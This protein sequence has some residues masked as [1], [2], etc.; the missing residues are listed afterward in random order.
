MSRNNFITDH[1]RKIVLEDGSEFY[2]YG[3]GANVDRVCELVFNTSMVGYQEIISDPANYCQAVVM[4]YPLIGNYG[5]SDDDFE[6][7]VP[8]VGGLIVRDYNDHPSNFSYTRTLS[9]VMEDNGVPGIYGFD[10]RALTRKI[11]DNGSCKVLFTNADTP[12][13]VAK[14]IINNAE[15]PHDSV[16][17]VSTRKRW[18]SRTHNPQFNIIAI[19][20]GI[21]HNAIKSMKDCG[22]NVTVVPWNTTSDVIEAM[23]P[24]A[25]YVSGGPGNPADIPETVETVQQLIGKYPMCGISLGHQLICLALGATTYK[26]NLGHRGSNHPIRCTLDS[27][28]IFAS[29]NHGY[30][31][32]ADSIGNTALQITHI[33]ALDNTLEGVQ[34]E[35]KRVFSVQ[36]QPDYSEFFRKLVNL[37]NESR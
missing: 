4:T 8:V 23:H 7:C 26:M 15:I 2:G 6:R 11:R 19:D 1:N 25:I 28:L 30:A 18:Y 20:C 12:L 35:E 24:D 14:D 16:S 32:D 21:N 13:D 29:Q 27:S 33:D 3:F 31:V 34:C 10:T 17:K 5:I 37:I 36:F 22:C 9:E